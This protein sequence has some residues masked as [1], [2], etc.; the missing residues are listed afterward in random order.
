MAFANG[1]RI[2][3]NG[4]VLSLDAGDR[5]SY[6]GS[7]TT[8]RDLS[9]N[10]NNG[11]LINSPT[12]NSANG[13]Y[14]RTNG[15][16]NYINIPASPSLNTTTPTVS[17]WF[18]NITSISG[19]P[20]VIHKASS[21]SSTNGWYAYLEG[22]GLT[23]AEKAG[24]PFSGGSSKYSG[25]LTL[26]TWYNLTATIVAGGTS[27]L[28]LNGTLVS[29]NNATENFTTTDDIRIGRAQTAFWNYWG[30]D[31]SQVLLYNTILTAGDITQ[32]YNAQKSRFGL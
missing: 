30:G 8:W 16:D 18:R 10:N 3:T 28:Y 23:F 19:F 12:Y 21:D 26:N 27:K 1:G 4:L 13:G 7:G 29:T 5:N 6:P 2:V 15:S 31:V 22:G 32:N 14:I 20:G 9:V 24:N 11:T 25:A 17:I